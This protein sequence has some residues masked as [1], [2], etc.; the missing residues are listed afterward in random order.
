MPAFSEEALVNTRDL[1]NMCVPN[2]EH[3]K[4][5]TAILQLLDE[6]RYASRLRLA[7]RRLGRSE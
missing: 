6:A 3:F 1:S 5:A 2:T 4:F 7:M